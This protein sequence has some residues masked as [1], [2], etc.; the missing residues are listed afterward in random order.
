M[1][2]MGGR[3]CNT[4]GKLYTDE[5]E[6]LINLAKQEKEAND[7]MKKKMRGR[8]KKFPDRPIKKTY[9]EFILTFD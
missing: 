5:K 1:N 7:K 2:D 8:P 6:Y 9:G 4:Q 3:R